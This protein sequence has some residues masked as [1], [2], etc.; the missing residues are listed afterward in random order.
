MHRF[1]AAVR[2]K[3]NQHSASELA[4]T[5]GCLS[6]LSYKPDREFLAGFCSTMQV[7]GLMQ[8]L[9]VWNSLASVTELPAVVLLLLSACT[10]LTVSGGST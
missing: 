5:L 6:D 9:V 3:M 7:R 4:R 8:G 2:L 1:L 10:I